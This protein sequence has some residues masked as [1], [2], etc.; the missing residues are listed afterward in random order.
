[1]NKFEIFNILKKKLPEDLCYVIIKYYE[2]I[3]LLK[4]TIS[5][6]NI[7]KL[8]KL[9]YIGRT[10]VHISDMPDKCT[11]ENLLESLNEISIP[12]SHICCSGNG[13]VMRRSYRFRK[14]K[15]NRIH[16]EKITIKKNN[17]CNCNIL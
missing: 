12:V 8:K 6:K 3:T 7:D 5:Q 2:D 17:N 9:L 11:I 1:M 14:Y 16:P 10:T 15:T 13:V 4:K